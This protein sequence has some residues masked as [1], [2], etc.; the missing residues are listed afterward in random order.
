MNSKKRR[1]LSDF[2]DE[3][4]VGLGIILLIGNIV[5]IIFCLILFA[6]YEG[7]Y[8]HNPKIIHEIRYIVDNNLIPK[9]IIIFCMYCLVGLV[10]VIVRTLIIFVYNGMK[11]ACSDFIKGMRE[12]SCGDDKCECKSKRK[13]NKYIDD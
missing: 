12:A 5:Y 10:C 9:F 7:G 2:L 4:Y 8:I 13:A 1:I 3:C 6:L 11:K